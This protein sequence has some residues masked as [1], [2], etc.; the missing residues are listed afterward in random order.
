MLEDS[1]RSWGRGRRLE[2]PVFVASEISTWWWRRE[3]SVI[4]ME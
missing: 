3:A 4:G 1:A 2:V